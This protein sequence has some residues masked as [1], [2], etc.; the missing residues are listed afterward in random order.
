[1]ATATLTV[2]K[3]FNV[4]TAG[5]DAIKWRLWKHATST[6]DANKYAEGTLSNNPDALTQNQFY[7]VQ[8]NQLVITQ[9]KGTVMTE[10]FVKDE[11]A[12]ALKDKTTYLELF[13]DA[14]G[15]DSFTTN[16]VA[17]AAADWTIA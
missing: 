17:C 13:S 16:R 14:G 7:R 2:E 4:G 12:G 5:Q 8:A 9:T 15:A 1:M 10:Q 11:L 6:T 3:I